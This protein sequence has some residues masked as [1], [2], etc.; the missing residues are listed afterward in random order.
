MENNHRYFKNHNCKYFPCHPQP[1]PSNGAFN[2]LF[3]YCPL[4]G[5]G[6]KCGGSFEYVKQVK[7]CMGCDFPHVPENYDIIVEKLKEMK[8]RG[9]NAN[10]E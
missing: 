1:T 7:T 2:C 4:Y 6:N 3:C 9:Q 5:L 8:K 10:S